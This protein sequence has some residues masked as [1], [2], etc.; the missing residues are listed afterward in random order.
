MEFVAGMIRNLLRAVRFLMDLL[1]PIVVAVR[2]TD[3]LLPGGGYSFPSK[4]RPMRHDDWAGLEACPTGY[5]LP[6][7]RRPMRQRRGLAVGGG[8]GCPT[9]GEPSAPRGRGGLGALPH[10]LQFAIPAEADAPEAGL[11]DVGGGG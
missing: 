8:R 5:S 7:Q 3:R 11:A 9:K 4:G 2:T 10:W 1:L 6:S